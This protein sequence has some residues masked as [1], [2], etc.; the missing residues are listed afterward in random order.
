MKHTPDIAAL[1]GSRICHDLIGPLSAI[2]N[3]VELLSL[4]GLPETPEMALIAD[5]VTSANAKIKFLRIAFGAASAEQLVKHSEV[6][7]ILDVMSKNSRISYDW[8]A[9]GM[10][11]RVQ[12]RALFL[13]IMCVETALPLGGEITIRGSGIHAEGRKLNI[14]QDHWDAAQNK[15]AA[16]LA[17]A[18]VQFAVLP[19]AASEAGMTPALSV[20]DGS[21]D[22]AL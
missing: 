9:D 16:E 21:L 10:L 2:G 11:T 20:A 14:V 7:A 1:I 3:G 18:H 13:A 5:S 12:L 6:V 19:W 22:L 17:A 4:A 8:Q 15:A